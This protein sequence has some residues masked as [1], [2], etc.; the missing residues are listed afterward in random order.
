MRGLASIILLSISHLCLAQLSIKPIAKEKAFIKTRKATDRIGRQVN[1]A[2]LPFWDDFSIT[3]DSPDSIRVWGTDTTFQWNYELSKDV[4]INATLAV[5]PPSHKVATFDGLDANGGF[6]GDGVGLTDQLVSDTID[7]QGKIDVVLSF[8]WQAG[9]NVEIPEEGDSL[10]LEFFN[11][12]DILD[13][14]KRVWKKDGGELNSNQDSVFTQEHITLTSDFLTSK[15]LFR[16][17]SFGDQDGPFDAWHIDWVYLNENRGDDDFFYEDVSIN[18]QASLLIAPFRA[19]PF[20]QFVTSGFIPEVTTTSMNLNP[21]PDRVGPS[22]FYNLSIVEKRN[23]NQLALDSA[24]NPDLR[25]F[26]NPDPDVLTLVN[27]LN[28]GT[29]ELSV[30]TT[31][32][33][34][35]LETEVSMDTT[36]FRFLDNSQINLRINDTIRTQSL[37][38]DYYAFDDGTA[39][40]AV[41]TNIN[42]GQVAVQFWLE[43]SDTLTYIDIYFPNIDPPSDGRPLTLNVF[44]RLDGGEP[45]RSQGITI[46][47]GSNINEFTRYKLQSPIQLSDTFFI[48]YQQQVNEYIGIGF[49]RNNPDAADYI[50]EN[51]AGEWEQNERLKGALMIRPVFASPDSIVTSAKTIEKPK[52]YPNPVNDWIKIE[53]TYEKIS[54]S[55]FSGRVLINDSFKTSHDLTSLKRGLYLLTIYRREGSQTIKIIKE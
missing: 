37:L 16:F 32:D 28:F 54:I 5:N 47:N 3:T 26:F 2:D 38:H 25:T 23:G 52:V 53:G 43:V 50:F 6:H 40:Y 7:L 30:L 29:Q 45:L 48:G 4:F 42:G 46:R 17:Q 36:D 33:S 12:N 22:T 9:G 11:P 14:W 55:D 35:V 18:S 1:Q 41:G 20:Q 24:F 31:S 39:E 13:P 8:Y 15:F 21:E 19:I 27:E 10:I 51:S 34:V 44:K 49:D